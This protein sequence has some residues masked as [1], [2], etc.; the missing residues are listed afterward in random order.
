MGH[1]RT[2]LEWILLLNLIVLDIKMQLLMQE[3]A[4]VYRTSH[5]L[6]E[7][8]SKI[9]DVAKNFNDVKVTDKSLI[10]NTDLIE[11]LELR[12]LLG[13]ASVTMHSAEARKESRGAHAREDYK[14]RDD[15][16]WMKHTVAHF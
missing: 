15:V 6:T 12:N 16:N 10:W 7:G 14:D 11:T 4:S 5:I 3:S 8:K 1:Y 9:D 13:C 2:M